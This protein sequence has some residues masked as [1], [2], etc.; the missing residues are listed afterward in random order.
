[1]YFLCGEIRKL[2]DDKELTNKINAHME[3]D[4]YYI[5]FMLLLLALN[6][7]SIIWSFDFG[8]KVSD[9]SKRLVVELS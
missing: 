8:C 3:D 1:M 7:V 9:L 2:E 6:L 4:T 5:I